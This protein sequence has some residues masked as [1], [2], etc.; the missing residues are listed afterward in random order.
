MTTLPEQLSAARNAQLDAQFNLFQNVTSRAFDNASRL[1][2]L[3]LAVSRESLERS[4][5]TVRQLIAT[6]NPQELGFLRSQAEEQMRSIAAYGHELFGLATGG[7]RLYIPPAEQPTAAPAPVQVAHALA[8]AGAPVLNA[9]AD[10]VETSAAAVERAA[11]AAV[12]A[13][14]DAGADAAPT[15]PDT[16]SVDQIIAAMEQVNEQLSEQLSEQVSEQVPEQALAEEPIVVQS[17][18]PPAAD[19]EPAPAAAPAPKPIAAAA[20]KGAPKAAAAA[21]P[22]AAPIASQDS[23]SVVRIGSK[24]PKRRK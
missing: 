19:A 7:L 6:T 12:D 10:S 18:A 1:M 13:A 8:E 2:A 3:N 4:S 11:E 14:L 23:A 16:P 15:L 24:S 17:A 9:V 5:Q 21:P 20:G 22:M